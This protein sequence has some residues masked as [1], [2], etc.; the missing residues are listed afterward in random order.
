MKNSFLRFALLSTAAIGTVLAAQQAPS[1]NPAPPPPQAQPRHT[2]DPQKQLNHLSKKL[3]LSSDQQNQILPILT[4]RQQQAAAIDSDSSLDQKQRRAK[5]KA[6]R[7]DSESR[8]RN[9]LNDNQRSTYDQM[10]QQARART[11][12]RRQ[13]TVQN[14]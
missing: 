3:A 8:L 13:T 10:Q 1:D 2:V 11:Q 5:L 4:D 7:S 14:Q 12:E 9:V 6:V